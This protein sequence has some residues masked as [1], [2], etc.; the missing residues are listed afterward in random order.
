MVRGTY[1]LPYGLEHLRPCGGLVEPRAGRRQHSAQQPLS[2]EK[3][4][5]HITHIHIE[6]QHQHHAWTSGRAHVIRYTM[7]IYTWAR[8][9]Y[10]QTYLLSRCAAQYCAVSRSS[11]ATLP[12]PRTVLAAFWVM[13]AILFAAPPLFSHVRQ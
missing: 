12:R 3:A 13:R 11:E 6:P 4:T 1:P 9:E 2:P 10:E 8:D 5:A 7:C